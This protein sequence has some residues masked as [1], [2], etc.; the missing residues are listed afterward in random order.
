MARGGGRKFN[1][2]NRNSKTNKFAKHGVQKK[3]A[4]GASEVPRHIKNF[5][6]SQ[7]NKETEDALK[8]AASIENKFR[9]RNE[10]FQNRHLKRELETMEDEPEV[11][12]YEKLVNS[13]QSSSKSSKAIENSDSESDEEDSEDSNENEAS[14]EEDL[15]GD[16]DDAE[17]ESEMEDDEEE[18]TTGNLVPEER[19][20][21]STLKKSLPQTEEIP[22]DP[23]SS[24]DQEEEEEDVVV[25]EDPYIK[26]Y[27]YEINEELVDSL[28]SETSSRKS[29]SDSNF[30]LLGKLL[31]ELPETE[32]SSP[33][34]APQTT[35]SFLSSAKKFASPGQKPVLLNPKNFSS[36]DSLFIKKALQKNISFANRIN[37]EKISS[38]DLTPLQWEL[39][40]LLGHYQDLYL[41]NRTWESAEELRFVYSLH[42]INH[43]LKSRCEVIK[44]NSTIS[45]H[46]DEQKR[47]KGRS[48]TTIDDEIRDQGLVRPKVLILAPLKDAG[49]RIVN[50]L[51]DL[52]IPAEKKAGRVINHKRFTEEFS[53]DALTFSKNNPKPDDY[54]ATFQ[55]NTD[56]NFR[57]GVSLT[58]K[59][60]KLYS[61]FYSS[62]LIV[63]SPLGL[64][65]IIGGQG[66]EERDFDFLAAVEVVIVDQMDVIF[67]QNW[68]HLLHVFKHMHLQLQGRENTDFSRVRSWALNGWTKFYR[69]TILIAPHDLPEFRSVLNSQC[70]NYRGKVRQLV[71]VD[72]G[73][74]R[75]CVVQVPQTFHRIEVANLEGSFDARFQY[76]T[77]VI[78][79]QFTPA[80]MAHTLVY[81]PSYF[82]FVRLR[83]YFKKEVTTSCVQICEY[84]RDGKVARARDMFY[85]SGAHFLLYTERS[86]FFRRP[87]VKGIRNLVFYQPP[88]WPHF[89]PEMVNLMQP[90]NQNPRDGLELN[91]TVTVLYTVYD[92]IQLSGILAT[93]NAKEMVS[94]GKKTHLF[95]TEK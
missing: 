78:L 81:I 19:K 70:W 55:G 87:R 95:V 25:P 80:T 35:S 91:M 73:S 3:K 39:L 69:Q 6:F 1:K 86:H 30:P 72:E 58:K 84:S 45:R 85:H 74:I 21:K 44:H 48:L 10:I 4:S 49:Y 63:A 77:N 94:G 34:K 16:D 93:K 36:L 7:R 12:Y 52:L 14:M 90:G 9:H 13:L 71:A 18:E 59:C 27:N 38:L 92:I 41:S 65:M 82:D 32:E 23:E 62:D 60:V 31:V 50:M 5:K 75:R 46:L 20:S 33:S 67:A 53:G 76:F 61:D 64:R 43:V 89:Y 79:P 42:A 88:T 11:D 37:A 8:R 17:E 40:P 24:S 2:N 47:T 22:E 15:S 54:K 29:K 66:D 56:D 26:C 68:D 51:I 83:N 28:E 57:I